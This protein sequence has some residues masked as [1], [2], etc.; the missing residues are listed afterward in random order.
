MVLNLRSEVF[1]MPVN[2]K[3]FDEV[4]KYRLLSKA[5]DTLEKLANYHKFFLDVDPILE[6]E[7]AMMFSAREINRLSKE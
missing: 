3:I 7:S 4:E 2:P 6:I 1:D 5:N